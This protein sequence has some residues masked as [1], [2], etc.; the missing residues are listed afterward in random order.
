[1]SVHAQRLATWLRQQ[2]KPASGTIRSIIPLIPHKAN[3][4][5]EPSSFEKAV[6]K[7]RARIEQAV[8]KLK[9]QAGRITL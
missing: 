5:H 6:Y 7:G 8:G 1:M 9:R 3:E 4:K 2:C